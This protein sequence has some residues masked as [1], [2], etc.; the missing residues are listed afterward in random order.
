[1]AKFDVFV[2]RQEELARI[3]EWAGEWGTSH[4]I[5]VDGD[6]GVGKTWLLLEALRRYAPDERYAVVYLDAAEH[7]YGPWYDL[8]FLTQQL[9]EE[10]FPVLLAGMDELSRTYLHLD[11]L[12][13]QARER[14]VLQAG[15]DEFNRYLAGQ[16]LI[17][18]GDTL[19][20]WNPGH[21]AGEPIRG[22]GQYTAQFSNALF[23]V[24]GRELSERMPAEERAFPGETRDI[25][26]RN[27]DRG[28]SAE[29]FDAVDPEGLIGADTRAKLHLLTDGRPVLLSLAVEWLRRAVPLPE[30]AD[31]SLAELR[32]LDE[33]EL[34]GL[35]QDFEF[36]LVDR[37]RGLKS[38]LDEAVLSMAHI[39]QRTDPRL[40]STLLELPL[41][42][43]EALV[44][45]LAELSFVKSNPISGNCMLHDEMKVLVNRHAW[46]YVDPSGEIRLEQTRRVIDAYYLPRI[47]ELEQQTKGWLGLERG[48]LRRAT[49]GREEWQRWRLESECLHYYLQISEREGLAYFEEHFLDARRNNHLLRM[50]FLLNEVENAG[51]ADMGDMLELR[52]AESLRLNQQFDRARTI[53]EN[54]LARPNL[55]PQNR[56]S[57]HVT[58]GLIAAAV[59]PLKAEEHYQ[60]ALRLA[61]EREDRELQ[62]AVHNNLGQLYRAIGQLEAAARHLQAAIAYSKQIRNWPLVASATNNLAYVYRQKGDLPQ[63]D[64]L[65]RVALAQRKQLGMER[66]L[67][68]S[69][70]NKAEID[71]DKGDLESAERY[72]KLAMRSFD[73]LDERRGQALAYASLA[74]IHRHIGQFQ[75]A[76]TYIQEGLHLAGQIQDDRLRARL[77]NV[78]GREQRDHAMHAQEL[79]NEEQA[80][81][82]LQRSLHYQELGL[83]L[84]GQ[85]GDPWLM[86]RGRYELALTYFLGRLRPEPEVAAL[87]DDVWED[88]VRLG[89][90]LVQGYVQEVRGEI[91]LRQGDHARAAEQLGQ[92]TLLMAQL[93]SRESNR[94]FDRISDYLLAADLASE[95]AIA[96][97]QGIL[98][99]ISPSG[100][101]AGP[102]Q[103]LRALCQQILE[104]QG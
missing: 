89:Y 69:Y 31:R 27:F 22:M 2:G 30:I 93:A 85:Y 35:C 48:P 83:E 6:G 8:R 86:T 100:G 34:R 14:A 97:S 12:E 20:A 81:E 46:P 59:E 10:H 51:Y 92:A 78:Y 23:V 24:A 55:S 40:L 74:N 54:A 4:L 66:E 103:P 102:L 91:S 96:L 37:V 60:Q 49:I 94:F 52:R 75:S 67:A 43:A 95:D 28:E 71:R 61:Q 1:M 79:G 56:A 90:T 32:A 76:E 18:L 15:V 98:D 58:L 65:C 72:T 82:L 70:L 42:E 3:D 45:S 44:S 87:L 68:Y 77:Y 33:A 25:H 17:Y 84:A 50:Q 21:R 80:A 47:A 64:A 38:P 11:P 101:G 9:G 19:E 7:P 39:D 13:Y 99:V 26:L 57:A 73:K 104:L 62:S 16:R 36:Q 88:A 5:V 63:A 29:F 53:C 41:S